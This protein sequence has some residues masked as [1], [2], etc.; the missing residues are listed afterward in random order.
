MASTA[1][2]M[3]YY[4]LDVLGSVRAISDET[5]R[6]VRRYDY[7]PFGEDPAGPTDGDTR[8]FTGKERDAETGL[9]YFGA[10]Y[11][12]ARDGRFTTADPAM[13]VEDN[14]V[15]PQRWNRY[16][17]VRNNPLRYTDPDGRDPQDP[18]AQRTFFVNAMTAIGSAAGGLL[19][20]GGGAAGGTA[21]AG[22]VGTLA[23]GYEGVLAGAAGGAIA[24]RAI[25]EG[26]VATVQWMSGGEDAKNVGDN[27]KSQGKRDN[28]DLTGGRDAAEKKFAEL[29]NGEKI[30]IDPMTGHQVSESGVRLR[31]NADGSARIDIPAGARQSMRHETIHFNDPS[32]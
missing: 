23:G 11:Y 24:G 20:M 12:A 6:L 25:A 14:L 26:V 7:L 27:A 32:R 16:A 30:T 22:P 31:V 18:K 1:D 8:R 29:T 4:H 9:D 13:T 10:R 3:T 19:G 15:D 2:E 28:T 17:Y 5:G 21:L